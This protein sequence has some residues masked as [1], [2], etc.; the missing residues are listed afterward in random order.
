M[1]IVEGTNKACLQSQ[2]RVIRKNEWLTKLL[3]NIKDVFCKVTTMKK[4]QKK[5]SG[6]LGDQM[7]KSRG[8]VSDLVL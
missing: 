8:T 6:K 7:E 5:T 4:S 3:E 1:A 2:A